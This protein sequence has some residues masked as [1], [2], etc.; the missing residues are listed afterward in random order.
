[1]IR[2][3][4]AACDELLKNVFLLVSNPPNFDLKAEMRVQKLSEKAVA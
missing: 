1:M 3:I 4:Y 2:F